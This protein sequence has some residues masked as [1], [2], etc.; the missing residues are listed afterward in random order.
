MKIKGQSLDEDNLGR[1]T[2]S[3]PDCD[4]PNWFV[5][6]HTKLWNDAIGEWKFEGKRCLPPRPSSASTYRVTNEVRVPTPLSTP[7]GSTDNLLESESR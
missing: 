6:D 1:F 2:D 4:V 7:L 3:S 5:K